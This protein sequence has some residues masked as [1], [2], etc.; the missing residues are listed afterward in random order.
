MSIRA[1]SFDHVALWVAD[2]DRLADF[3]CDHLGM[4][5]IERSDDFTLVGVDARQGKLT[6]FA[7][8]GPREADALKRVVLRVADLEAA[9]AELPDDLSLI[10]SDGRVEFEG[11]EGLQLG[12]VESEGLE[13]DL[14]H[15]VLQ[16][17]AADSAV[18][19]LAELGFERRN[20][21]LA[22]G[23]RHLEVRAGG[24]GEV[25]RPLLNHLA[26]LVDSA[27]AAREEAEQ[28]GLEIEKVVDAENTFAVFVRGPDGITVE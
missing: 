16:V 23:D 28:R 19:A 20:G 15:A 6:L 12:L 9:V 10:R 17:P 1:K 24:P 11:P 3:L 2:R 25:E 22:V 21:V 5:V 7:A 13:Y 27:G 18:E 26:L 4:H 14:D 8:E